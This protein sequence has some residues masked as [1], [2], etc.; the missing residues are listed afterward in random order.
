MLPLAQ[1]MHDA[2]PGIQKPQSFLV[3]SGQ[4]TFESPLGA[5]V[6]IERRYKNI[7]DF[8]RV[9]RERQISQTI[10]KDI[11]F[12]SKYGVVRIN[13]KFLFLYERIHPL[14][15]HCTLYYLIYSFKRGLVSCR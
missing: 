1:K 2:T 13:N 11:H 9:G 14:L 5:T 4:H 7:T 10:N 12:T 15:P 8:Y 3:Y 6:H